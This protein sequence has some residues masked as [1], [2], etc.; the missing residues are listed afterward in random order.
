MQK[1]YSNGKLLLSGEYLILDGATGLALPTSYGQEMVV[2]TFENSNELHWLSLDAMENSWFEAS[3]KLSDLSLINLK[4]DR[5]V[6]L[7]LSKILLQAKEMHPEF[8]MSNS[9][10]QVTTKLEFPRNWGLGSSSTLINNIAQWA[11]VDAFHLLFDSFGGSGYDIACAQHDS[12]ILYQ[13]SH[14]FPKIKT[15]Q[16]DPVFK[17]Q[18]YFVYLN[19]KQVS[20]DS[21]RGYRSKKKNEKAL[22]RVSEL[23]KILLNAANLNDFNDG[24]KEHESILASILETR[25]IQ[26][27]LFTDFKGQ[28][29]SLGAW[30]GDFILA[31]G[32]QSTPSYF[33]QKGYTTILPF[34][35]MIKTQ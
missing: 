31:T 5:E 11:K 20:S 3:F 22:N 4:G 27:K 9:G 15:V 18:I 7:T 2:T 25:P 23:S 19:Q 21:I 33:A 6:A 1:F 17:D 34:S 26:E 10:L 13:L 30:G 35:S 14:Q 29:K 12:P 32:D 24:L 8:L 28:T 16:F